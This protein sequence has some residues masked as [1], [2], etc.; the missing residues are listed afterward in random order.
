[1]PIA[2][3][4]TRDHR[5]ARADRDGRPIDRDIAPRAPPA[6]RAAFQIPIVAPVFLDDAPRNILQR[7]ALTGRA[8]RDHIERNRATAPD[9]A[10]LE[11]RFHAHISVRQPH[12]HR[13]ALTHH[14]PARIGNARNHA[15]AQR[16]RRR[17]HIG[18]R[19]HE[20][21]S[22][23]AVRRRARQLDHALG[24]A[25]VFPAELEAALLRERIGIDRDARLRL[26][27]KP[28]ARRAIEEVRLHRDRA[29]L[30][31]PQ[32]RFARVHPHAQTLRHEIFDRK[33]NAA[34]RRILP[35]DEQ[36]RAPHPARRRAI[37]R[38]VLRHRARFARLGKARAARFGA[39]RAINDERRLPVR[40]R[41]AG[42]IAHEADQTHTLAGAINAALR[43]EISV[44]IARRL[45][46]IDAAIGEIERAA[47]EIERREIAARAIRHHVTRARRPFAFE[48]RLVEMHEPIGIGARTREL[49]VVLRDQR[50]RDVGEWPRRAQRTRN[51]IH[52]SRAFE[53]L[54]R[55]VGVDDPAERERRAVIVLPVGARARAI[56][57]DAHDI[58]AWPHVPQR[59]AKREHRG[60][61]LIA[62][63]AAAILWPIGARIERDIDL[64]LIDFDANVVAFA[65]PAPRAFIEALADLDR[66]LRQD[67]VRHAQ[68]FDIELGNVHRLDREAIGLSARQDHAIA[69]KA[70]ISGPVAERERERLVALRSLAIRSRQ[71]LPDRNLALRL[72][73]QTSKAQ[74][75][76]RALHLERNGRIERN[77]VR[78]IDVRLRRKLARKLDTRARRG[79]GCVNARVDPR[80]ALDVLPG[81]ARRVGGA[82]H[83]RARGGANRGDVCD[84]ALA[85]AHA[86]EHRAAPKPGHQRHRRREHGVAV[87]LPPN[88]LRH[89]ARERQEPIPQP[90]QIERRHA[91]SPLYL[92]EDCLTGA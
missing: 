18:E 45:A 36:L 71:P 42:R 26:H 54:Q 41:A 25:F 64:A 17:R 16:Q 58:R 56:V 38:D 15:R 37:E 48:Q 11:L 20:L 33:R 7:R 46:P 61:A 67:P 85:R 43:V 4:L 27:R 31:R 34:R 69:G 77:V 40:Q 91:L 35:I 39:V 8:H 21:R 73:R 70:D 29:L 63:V 9:A 23:R 1:M 81:R 80:H 87:L 19:K 44:H 49:F 14:A 90:R 12:R 6:P 82:H 50:Q 55:R 86:R 65:P 51:D 24:E 92:E 62:P 60:D 79:T 28:A 72:E 32:R 89:A 52:P 78:E 68:H 53:R 59:G 83:F 47:V 10:V 74:K 84:P 57:A 2:Q 13:E 30:V 3:P 88:R 66:A 22:P 76:A 75:R 5:P